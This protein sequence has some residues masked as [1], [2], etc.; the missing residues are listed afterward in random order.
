[1]IVVNYMVFV[2]TVVSV[3]IWVLACGFGISQHKLLGK[4]YPL[5][6]KMLIGTGL[7]YVILAFAANR[8]ELLIM[9]II[10]FALI[11]MLFIM[12]DMGKKKSARPG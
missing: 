12:K 5:A 2:L 10:L 1:M 3:V 6:Q 8:S 4:F 9:T 11:L 7:V